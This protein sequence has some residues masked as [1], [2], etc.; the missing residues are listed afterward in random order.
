VFPLDGFVGIDGA[1]AQRGILQD[2]VHLDAGR[3]ERH[4]QGRALH[5]SGNAADVLA[6]QHLY[7]LADAVSH[8]RALDAGRT[9]DLFEPQQLSAG[10][11][12][13]NCRRVAGSGPVLTR[14]FRG[15]DIWLRLLRAI[16][17][18]PI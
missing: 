14:A 12:E 17:D 13:V 7:Y 2:F 18:W 1:L 5:L 10:R 9:V 16:A 4:Q 11:G 15:C 3:L 8:P 6:V